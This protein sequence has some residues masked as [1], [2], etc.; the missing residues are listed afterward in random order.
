M[1]ESSVYAPPKVWTWDKENG[2]QFASINRPVAGATHDKELPV[3]GGS[4][5]AGVNPPHSLPS[6]MPPATSTRER[7]TSWMRPSDPNFFP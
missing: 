7:R 1:S 2:G 5:A 6:G 4:T 3:G